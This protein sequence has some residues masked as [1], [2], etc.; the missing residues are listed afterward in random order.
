VACDNILAQGTYPPAHVPRY[1]R[2]AT[3]LDVHLW[4]VH[5]KVQHQHKNMC[6]SRASLGYSGTIPVQHRAS[7]PYLGVLAL[8]LHEARLDIAQRCPQLVRLPPRLLPLHHRCL[9]PVLGIG[10]L[11]LRADTRAQAQC[12]SAVVT[13]ASS[14][15]VLGPAAQPVERCAV[16]ARYMQYDRARGIAGSAA[17]L[18]MRS[19]AP[20]C[21][22]SNS[23]AIANIFQ[24]QHSHTFA[25]KWSDRSHQMRCMRSCSSSRC[26]RCSSP[27][28]EWSWSRGG[29]GRSCG[30]C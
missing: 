15:S 26:S 13:A 9:V 23:K 27:P 19:A 20:A 30:C 28:A 2:A 24:E 22:Q 16:K 8:V 17:L 4:P 7:V 25:T 21:S 10:Q 18:I 1:L 14:S 3:V 12:T 5:H 11:H 29:R 6:Y